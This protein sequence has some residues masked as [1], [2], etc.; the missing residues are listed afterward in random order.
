MCVWTAGPHADASATLTDSTWRMIVPMTSV[1][2]ETE[3]Q[4]DIQRQRQRQRDGQRQRQRDRDIVCCRLTHPL[5]LCLLRLA[6]NNIS[7]S[8]AIQMC[9]GLHHCPQLEMLGCV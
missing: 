6:D 8:G 4:R 7:D 2:R 1:Y 9:E 3:K 5:L